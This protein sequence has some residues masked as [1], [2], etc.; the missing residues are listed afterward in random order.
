MPTSNKILHC[1]IDFGTTNSSLAISSSG[2]PSI[3]S[4]DKLNSNPAIL[5]SLIYLNPKQQIA[6]G[7]DAINHYLTDLNTLPSVPLR[8]ELTG[9]MIKTFGP[10]GYGGAGPVIWV[11]EIV[12]IDD[13]GRGRLLQSLKSV[14]TSTVFTGTQIF[15][16]FYTLEDLLTILLQQIKTRAEAEINHELTSVVIGRPVR[17]VGQSE[18]KIALD[19]M[20]QI[21]VNSG[22]KHIEFEYE[23][24]GAALN[25][26]LNVNTNQNILVYDFGGGTLDIC[27]MKLPE[28][29]ILAVSGR[30]VGGDLLDSQIVKSHLL[31]HFGANAIINGRLPFP[32]HFFAAFNSWYQT[33]LQKTINNI[34]SLRKLA[35]ESDNPQ[36]I[37]NLI[38]LINHDY[39]FEFFRSVDNAKITLTD[40]DTF[41]FD[42]SRPHLS[43]KQRLTRSGFET[44][45]ANE[46]EES[47]LCIF[48][49]L[50]QA[51]LKPSNIDKIILTG[52]SSQIPI[53]INQIK[54]I[55]SPDKIISSDHFTS[56]ASG[57][58][59]H[60]E[61]LFT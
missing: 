1:G 9:R 61:Q 37:N 33:T 31:H 21:A 58:A 6:V 42:F 51:N 39:G 46:I 50:T 49:S 19:H 40:T 26:G 32:K 25:Y 45:I 30:G 7:F 35:I 36:P 34:E 60:A 15:G 47:R 56:V 23:P 22:F 20:H 57:L 4:I 44:A 52:G 12:E 17:Y 2:V 24:V 59:I 38:N 43:I 11:P 3:I 27:I 48:E 55:F 10:S 28:K 13:S 5:R 16:K 53:F 8:Q 41:N 14:L 29:K 54:S 18:N